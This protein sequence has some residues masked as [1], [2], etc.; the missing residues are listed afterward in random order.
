MVED[1]PD[2]DRILMPPSRSP[3]PFT[4][5]S[6]AQGRTLPT[7]HALLK[8]PA[9]L[10]AFIMNIEQHD[11]KTRMSLLPAVEK[12][13]EEI[14]RMNPTEIRKLTLT[15][16]RH[17]LRVILAAIGGTV[18]AEVAQSTS[19]L[20]QVLATL[21]IYYG[22]V[23]TLPDKQIQGTSQTGDRKLA[24]IRSQLIAAMNPSTPRTPLEQQTAFRNR[25]D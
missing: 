2:R 25:D 6:V 9:M 7:P 18:A 3:D 19:F 8:Y 20:E 21:L 14:D 4:L 1:I 16:S 23:K 24:S 13:L 15:K 12:Y 5:I 10:D 17:R 11:P 22:L